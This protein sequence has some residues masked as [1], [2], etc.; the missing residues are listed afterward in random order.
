LKNITSINTNRFVLKNT[1]PYH[2][3]I[4]LGK[5][6]IQLA[7]SNKE[8]AKIEALKTYHKE[9]GNITK[10]EALEVFEQQIVKNAKHCYVGLES[11]KFT[12]VPTELF[13][14]E[15]KS[16]YLKSIY[17]IAKEETFSSQK[18]T[19][20]KAHSIFTL[21][22]GTASLL[23]KEFKNCTILHAP[24]TLLIAYQ[25]LVP[26]NKKNVSFARLQQNE[27]LVTVFQKKKLLLHTSFPIEN[28]EDALFQYFN[29]IKEL[30][31]DKKSI[32]LNTLGNHAEM[33]RFNSIVGKNVENCKYVNR[34]P[35]L[36]YNDE[37]FSHPTHHF[38]NLF[39][40]VLCA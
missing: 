27:I 16:D 34:L 23:E 14:S 17:D 40:L 3:F 7:V 11:K 39:S 28:L 4:W 37:V 5:N 19:P 20:V 8:Q 29:A 9:K 30:G 33:D 13:S 15:N 1:A 38:F 2:V 24:S 32:S 26:P 25:Q 21:K 6:F 18:I 36:Q 10:R 22:K 31:I 12:L 35:I